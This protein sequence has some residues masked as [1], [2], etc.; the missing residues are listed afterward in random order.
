MAPAI[1]KSGA[2][3]SSEAIQTF[4]REWNDTARRAKDYVEKNF[5]N[6]GKQF[7]EEARRQHYG[8]TD[9]KPIFGEATPKEVRELK[10]EGV[11]VAPVPQPVPEPSE[12]KK[13]LN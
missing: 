5:E 11:T 13:K 12:T 9:A 2:K 4:A 1:V 7:P 6:V 3:K 10:E 8:E